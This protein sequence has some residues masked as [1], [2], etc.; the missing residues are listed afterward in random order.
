M[1]TAAGGE[2]HW[3]T[4]VS[5]AYYSCMLC[6][7]DRVDEEHGEDITPEERIHSWLRRA[8]R[9]SGKWHLKALAR[10]LEELHEF[11]EH[12]DYETHD[13]WPTHTDATDILARADRFNQKI[14]GLPS[15]DILRVRA[16]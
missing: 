3:R 15:A 11:R 6:L 4:A 2:L 7:R 9:S 14:L 5:R 12:A 1:N 16:G 8:L 13:D 10:E